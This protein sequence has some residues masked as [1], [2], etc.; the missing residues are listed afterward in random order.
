MY[1]IYKLVKKKQKLAQP[2]T[3]LTKKHAW[4]DWGPVQHG[5]WEKLRDA[6][7]SYQVIVH[8]QLNNPYKLYTDISNLPQSITQVPW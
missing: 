2:L 8:P 5:A 7:A 1:M 3:V 6:L 4:F